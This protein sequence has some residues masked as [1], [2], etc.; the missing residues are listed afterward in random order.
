MFYAARTCVENLVDRMKS[1]D[2]NLLCKEMG[3][4]FSPFSTG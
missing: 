1:D 3:I 4:K 2:D